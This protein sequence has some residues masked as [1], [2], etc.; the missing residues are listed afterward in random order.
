MAN[1][2]KIEGGKKIRL[3]DYD[4]AEH[5]KL[6]R[7]EAEKKSD[8]LGKEMGE[9]FD[10]LYEAGHNSLLLIL[11]GRD[12]SGKDGLIRHLLSYSNAQSCQVHPFKVPSADEIAHDFLWRVHT[13][14][15]ARGSISVFN[16]SHYEDVLVVRVH[17]LVPD[18]IWKRR[19]DYIN[20][21]EHSL[22]DAD[23]I[24]LKFCLHISKE[25][26]EER[27]LARE[28]ETTK[29]WKLSVGDWKER[30][31]W[32]EYTEAYEDLLTRCSSPELPW[33]I[34]PA[35]HKWYRNLAVTERIV[36]AL[37]PYKKEWLDHLTKIGAVA[38]KEI[39]DYR[40]MQ[41]NVKG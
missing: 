31:L 8:E 23:T 34:I 38:K 19:Y 25:E 30:E 32:D 10:L 18:N 35:N 27:L 2:F 4:P 7:A 5:G 11:Q 36:D 39:E 26:Q 12:T 29:F 1:G 28:E 17:N 20:S 16:R 24:V 22:V 9:L 6:D 13:R 41:K 21:F 3:S 15:P 37:K 40:Q 14:T 33:Y